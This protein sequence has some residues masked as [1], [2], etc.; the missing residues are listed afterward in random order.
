[1][2]NLALEDCFF[3][4]VVSDITFKS[5]Y[6]FSMSVFKLHLS[7]ST[8]NNCATQCPIEGVTDL[9][10]VQFS[11][12]LYHSSAVGSKRRSAA[13]EH[14]STH[15]KIGVK[16]EIIPIQSHTGLLKNRKTLESTQEGQ[17]FM[18]VLSS[19]CPS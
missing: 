6:V 13:P 8:W 17:I 9:I 14:H 16:V 18:L 2:K 7:S 12:L 19:S 3:P 5:S 1:M 15:V 10:L 11:Q 4:F